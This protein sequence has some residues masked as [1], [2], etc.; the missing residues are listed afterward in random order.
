VN[1]VSGKLNLS[2]VQPGMR[3]GSPRSKIVRVLAAAV[4]VFAGVL[5]YSLITS[6]TDYISYWSAGKLLMHHADPYS[7]EGALALEKAEGFSLGYMVMLN[8]PWAVFLAAPLGFVGIRAGL[9]LWTLA[10]VTCVIVSA[11]LLETTPKA[12]AF[13]YVFAPAVA[14]VYMGQSSPFLLLGFALFLHFHRSRPFLA[15][16]SLLLMAIKPHLFLIFWALLLVDCIYRRRLLILAGLASSLAA[17]TAF[18]MC[19]DP[20]IWPHYVAMLRR[21]TLGHDF[22]PTLSMLFRM[23]IDVRAFWLLF[24][25]SVFAILWGLWY[26]AR[27]RQVWDW[28]VHGM[29]VMLVT[30]LAS[31]YSWLTDEAVLLPP[32]LFALSFPQKRKDSAWILLAINSIVLFLVLGKQ[33]ALISHAYIWTPLTWLVWFLYA[34]R[35]DLNRDQSPLNAPAATVESSTKEQSAAL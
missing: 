16:A 10:T 18:A 32:I 20:H 1:S 15:G 11:Q 9:F 22:F 25:P 14:A 17:A 13:A 19:F 3:A 29:L 5:I 30:I 7:P 24:V 4:I 33:Y 28:K 8:P 6:R 12:R 26:Y 23:L 21:T 2:Q 35:G 31:P 27:R 34:T